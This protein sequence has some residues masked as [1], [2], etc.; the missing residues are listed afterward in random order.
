MV[1]FTDGITVYELKRGKITPRDEFSIELEKYR[2]NFSCGAH[3][4]NHDV[5]FLQQFDLTILYVSPARNYPD[6]IY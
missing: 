5:H 6:R 4:P 2:K 3:I 1:R